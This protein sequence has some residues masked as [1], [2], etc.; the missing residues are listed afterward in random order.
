MLLEEAVSNVPLS[1]MVPQHR[2]MS[3]CVL[4]HMVIGAAC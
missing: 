3:G 2:R 1:I 4:G